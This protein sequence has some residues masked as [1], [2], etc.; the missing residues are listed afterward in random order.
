MAL[1]TRLFVHRHSKTAKQDV[2]YTVDGDN[3]ESDPAPRRSS[4]WKQLFAPKQKDGNSKWVPTLSGIIKAGDE[5]L[6]TSSLFTHPHG[7]PGEVSF[8]AICEMFA[9]EL[10]PRSVT[11][12]SAYAGEIGR[13]INAAKRGAVSP[14]RVQ[15]VSYKGGRDVAPP[16]QRKSLDMSSIERG[17]GRSLSIK[18]PAPALVPMGNGL[19]EQDS[20]AAAQHAWMKDGRPAEYHNGRMGVRLTRGE[21]AALSLILGSAITR[22]SSEGEAS[23]A[24]ADKGAFGLSIQVTRTDD[25]R[26]LVSLRQHKRSVSQMPPSSAGHSPLFAKHLACGSLPFS[27]DSTAIN[28]LLITNETLDAVRSGLP[29]TLRKRAQQSA[30]VQFLATL[31]SSRT[32]ALHTLTPSTTPSAPNPLIDAI[33]HLPFSGGLTPLASA[34]LMAATHFIAG[35]GLAPG[36]LLQRLDALVD[37]VQRHAPTPNVFGALHEPQNAGLLF[38]E[39]ERVARLNGSGESLCDATA[40]VRRHAALLQRLVALVPDGGRRVGA[41][42]RTATANELRTAHADA[43][44]AYACAA[45]TAA[46]NG[47]ASRSSLGSGSNATLGSGPA[48]LP[49]RDLGKLTERLLKAQLPFGVDTVAVVARLVLVAWTMSA[50]GVV[51]EGGE[52]WRVEGVDGGVWV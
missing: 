6:W 33:A 20:S 44:A 16:A 17:L 41:A 47:S 51:W 12:R 40:R 14:R 31:P 1:V 10:R 25:G 50:R 46:L 49:A 35:G 38:R 3:S 43:V 36:R 9:G 22:T 28:S 30:Q 21:V 15:S 27:Q 2:I 13:F 8:E 23:A 4:S 32:L 19:V 26:H 39:R 24:S 37:K 34:P 7:Q 29:L 45:Q 52:G 42:V 48:A 11:E 5:G 18:R